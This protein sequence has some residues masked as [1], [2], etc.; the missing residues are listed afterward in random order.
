MKKN[1]ENKKSNKNLVSLFL[2][3]HMF[4]YIYIKEKTILFFNV[5]M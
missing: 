1:I 4:I 3:T 2:H 5:N